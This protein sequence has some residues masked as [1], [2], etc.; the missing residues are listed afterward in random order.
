MLSM[1]IG[2]LPVST[3][4]KDLLQEASTA[5]DLPGATPW[6]CRWQGSLALSLGCSV[7]YFFYLFGFLGSYYIAIKPQKG[8]TVVPGVTQQPT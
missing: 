4:V 7:A 1:G 6:G 5:A 2:F 3:F 8:Y